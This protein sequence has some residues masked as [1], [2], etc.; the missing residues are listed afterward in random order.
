MNLVRGL[1]EKC[2]PGDHGPMREKRELRPPVVV[3]TTL[4]FF[5]RAT[6]IVDETWR[7]LDRMA[8]VLDQRAA[9]LSADSPDRAVLKLVIGG[10]QDLARRLEQT[11]VALAA[12][13]PT[14]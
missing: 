8:A 4:P 5:A 3:A 11:E 13:L 1:P 10:I 12:Y 9:E 2:R 14:P 7:D 6:T